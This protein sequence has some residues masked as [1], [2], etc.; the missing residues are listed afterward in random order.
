MKK[1]KKDLVEEVYHHLVH[2][3]TKITRT[4]IL[5]ITDSLLTSMKNTLKSGYGIELRGFGVFEL[6]YRKPKSHARNP[7]TGEAVTVEGHTVAAF[8]AGNELRNDL[9]NM[10]SSYSN[11]ESPVTTKDTQKNTHTNTHNSTDTSHT[12][13]S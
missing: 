11:D 12:D 6:R 9:W 13:T 10:D 2:N 1:T 3:N 5:Q 4:S 7:K 8:R